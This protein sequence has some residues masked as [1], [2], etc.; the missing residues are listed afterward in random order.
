MQE[1]DRQNAAQRGTQILHPGS[2]ALFRYWE[3]I[4][5]ERP[6]PARSNINLRA[7]VEILPDLVILEKDTFNTHWH[8]RLAGTRVCAFFKGEVTGS[9]VLAE[10]EPFEREVITKTLDMTYNKLQ[11]SLARMRFITDGGFT[12]AAELIGLPVTCTQSNTTQILGGLF[13]F[14]SHDGNCEGSIIRREL[15]STR[16]IW[17]EHEQASQLFDQLGYKASHFLRLIQGGLT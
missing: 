9:D 10:W 7:I 12:T 13:L 4:R 11:P 3:S 16:M 5:A 15:I 14:V 8:Y 6:C 2:R 17:T 1:F